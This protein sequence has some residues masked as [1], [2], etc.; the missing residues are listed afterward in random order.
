[1]FDEFAFHIERGLMSKNSIAIPFRQVQNVNHEQSFSEKMWGVA[2]VVVETAGTDDVKNSHS[3]GLLPLLD[4]D[5]AQM[6]EQE[7]LRRSSGK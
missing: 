2:R 5:T 6:L 1:M 7:L 4:V 3:D